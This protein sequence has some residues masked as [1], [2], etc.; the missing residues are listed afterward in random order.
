MKEE[1]ND[2]EISF[3]ANPSQHLEFILC[4]QKQSQCFSL[5]THSNGGTFGVE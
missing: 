4:S 1:L 3:S 5:S 2:V